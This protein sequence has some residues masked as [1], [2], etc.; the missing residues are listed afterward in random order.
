MREEMTL[1]A[2]CEPDAGNGFGKEL[3]AGERGVVEGVKF[4]AMLTLGYI[5]SE[6]SEKLRPPGYLRCHSE[7][8]RMQRPRGSRQHKGEVGR[9]A[10]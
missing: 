6:H 7:L 10:E 2:R 1:G 8:R 3:W 9:K 4:C 5:R